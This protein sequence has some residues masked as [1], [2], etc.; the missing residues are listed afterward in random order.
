VDCSIGALNGALIALIR[1][2]AGRVAAVEDQLHAGVPAG[3]IGTTVTRLPS[4]FVGSARYYQQL[5]LDALALP[6]RFGK[7]DL[8]ITVTCNP[9]WPEITNALPSNSKWRDHPDIVSRAFMLRLKCIVNDFKDGNIFGVMKAFVY[10]IEWQA[11][12]LPHAHMLLI[13]EHK[14][15]ATS[16][17]DAIVSAEMPDPVLSPVLHALVGKHMLHPRCDVDQ[18]PVRSSCRSDCNG[19]LCDCK[20]RFPKDMCSAT[21]IIGDGFPK[22]RRRGRHLMTDKSGRII[23]DSWVVPYNPY[24]LLKYQTHINIEICAH[25]RSFKYVYKYTFKSPDFTTISVDEIM[26]HLS[27]RLLSASEAV[28]RLLS[29]PLHKEWPPIMRLEIHLPRQQNVVFNPTVDEQTLIA[30]LH[31]TVS[32]LMAWFQLN[33][34]DA[35][36]RTLHYIEVPEHYTWVVSA[37]GGSW[38]R[39]QIRKMAVGRMYSVSAQNVELHSLRRLLSV[40]KGATSFEDLATVD[41]AVGESFRAALYARG[42]MSDD[43]DII[44]TMFA[45]VG[46]E[47]SL[48]SIRRHFARILV[49]NPPQ[50]AQRLFHMFAADMCDGDALDEAV[51]SAALW[52]LEELMAS[53]GRSLTHVDYGFDLP[54]APVHASGD[55]DGRRVR[56]RYSSSHLPIST[57]EATAE[58]HHLLA[59]FTAEQKEAFDLVMASIGSQRASN[60]FTALASAGC[61]KTVFANGL[62]AAVRS[63]GKVAVSVAA[64]ALAAML[65]TGGKTAHSQFHIPIPSND[66]T[67]CHFTYA[68]KELIRSADLILWDECSMIHH[69]TADTVERSLRD[70]LHDDRPFGG[71]CVVFMGDFKQLLPVVRYGSGHQHTIQKC[72]WWST[73]TRI[74]FSLN[75]RAVHNPAYAAEL[76][77][78]GSGRV[79]AVDVPDASKEADIAAMIDAVYGCSAP[80]GHQILALTLATCSDVNKLCLERWPGPLQEHFAADTYTDGRD[81]DSCPH[82]YVESLHL[83]GAPP[84]TLGLKVGAR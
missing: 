16:Q 40:V 62:A 36:A 29:L 64:S 21:S 65:L 1:Y 69:D 38:R 59:L 31:S 33:I 26:D 74:S 54:A 72:S 79:A 5:Y 82:E 39:R 76:E 45:I 41:G 57:A 14:I 12:G 10:R 18:R 68:E 48:P 27:G 75:W 20:R 11:R 37:N 78:I 60:V 67:T 25:I 46:V 42:L 24:L 7:P 44:A 6:R 34:Q 8:F 4:S 80:A 50:D 22:Y 63:R 2:R 81:A 3:E 17:I 13:L 61:G 70:V 51:L 73:A 32:T 35:F 23:T 53:M 56:P 9:S 30:Q 83:H 77:D 71:K 58:M 55:I 66:R 15:M 47:T 19:K 52:S 49:H 43:A 84:F 28:H